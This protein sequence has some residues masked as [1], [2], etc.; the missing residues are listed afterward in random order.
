MVDKHK[1]VLYIK[2]RATQQGLISTMLCI[3]SMIYLCV[4]ENLG[5]KV[6]IP[7]KI[8]LASKH[9][10]NSKNIFKDL[11]TY[12]NFPEKIEYKH[13]K[14][15][16]IIFVDDDNYFN[17]IYSN[18]SVGVFASTT[19][20]STWV[21]SYLKEIL[22]PYTF[23][24]SNDLNEITV[25][26]KLAKYEKVI[27]FGWDNFQNFSLI[28]DLHFNYNIKLHEKAEH[29]IRLMKNNAH[30]FSV[31]HLRRGDMLSTV[32][33]HPHWKYIRSSSEPSHLFKTIKQ[34]IAPSTSLYI[35]TNGTS[36]YLKTLTDWLKYEYNVFTRESFSELTQMHEED[37]YELFAL[38]LC[39]AEKSD[40]IISNRNWGNLF[41]H[42][43]VIDLA[44]N[45][46]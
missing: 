16:E 32:R 39:L 45:A 34:H 22:T 14:P 31:L 20:G 2:W 24:S 26:D 19:F 23:E 25:Y 28:K 11:R 18:D 17:S 43:E 12:Y 33:P 1:Y 44:P 46:Y 13:F 35:M 5:R 6:L 15:V 7:N 4:I 42:S 29:L 27:Y 21:S 30:S 40:K 38:E 10:P 36:D 41:K 8:N 3:Q 9:S 37:N